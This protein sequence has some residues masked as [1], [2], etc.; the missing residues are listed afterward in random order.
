MSGVPE[1]RQRERILCIFQFPLCLSP[2]RGKLGARGAASLPS[3]SCPGTVRVGVPGHR[4][5]V[6]RCPPPPSPRAVKIVT[7]LFCVLGTSLGIRA[8]SSDAGQ[9]AGAQQASCI[10][11]WGAAPVCGVRAEIASLLQAGR[12]SSAQVRSSCTEHRIE[13]AALYPRPAYP[14]SQGPARDPG[15]DRSCR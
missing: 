14:G 6:P 9:P 7:Q 1:R 4:E 11:V 13:V 10:T 15:P 3:S 8:P 12:A 2:C 5:G